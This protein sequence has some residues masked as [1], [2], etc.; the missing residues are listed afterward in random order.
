MSGGA[1]GWELDV[2]RRHPDAFRFASYP[3]SL[4]AVGSGDFSTWMAGAVRVGEVEFEDVDSFVDN[5]LARVKPRTLKEL[6][7]IS[8][9]DNYS[10]YFS[11]ADEDQIGTWNFDNHRTKFRKLAALFV[12]GGTLVF[13]NC[14]VGKTPELLQLF[15]DT[16][17]VTV[18]GYTGVSYTAFAIPTGERIVR[19][20]AADG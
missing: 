2:A 18:V 19:E 11:D 20:P 1:G 8:H 6:T 5:V 7:V 4:T 9:G 13:R 10:V 15:A 16:L 12:A 17:G 14:T 3:I